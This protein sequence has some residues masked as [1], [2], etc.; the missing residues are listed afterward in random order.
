MRL[1]G[2]QRLGIIASVIYFVGTF[3]HDLNGR[4]NVAMDLAGYA[5]DRCMKESP[6]G[7]NPYEKCQKVWHEDFEQMKQGNLGL[8]AITAIT[9]IP[10]AWLFA[11]IARGLYRWVRRGF[12]AGGPRQ[13]SQRG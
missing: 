8:A 13:D 3:L 6:A 7:P 2:W 1:S 5:R 11:W 4:S 10:F 9:P 12:Q